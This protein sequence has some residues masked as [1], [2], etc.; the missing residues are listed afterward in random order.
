MAILLFLRLV[1]LM[2]F[3]LV[4]VVEQDNHIRLDTQAVALVVV[5][6]LVLRHSQLFIF[7]LAHMRLM[8]VLEAVAITVLFRLSL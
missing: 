8:L 6:L 7:L 3:L 5:E 1:C 2:C 4:A